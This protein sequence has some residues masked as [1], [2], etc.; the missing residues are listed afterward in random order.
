MTQIFSSSRGGGP[1]IFYD[2]AKAFSEMG[3]EVYIIC[4]VATDIIA[5]ENV[6]I[7]TVKP[8]LNI[9][10]ELPPSLIANLRYVINSLIVGERLVRRHKIQLIHTNSFTPVIAGSVLSKMKGIPM[11][12]SIYDVFA[13]TE[14]SN[15]SKWAHYNK[16]PQ[17][18]SL[19][20]RLYERISLRMP[21]DLIH[22]VSKTSK[23][24][25]S[26]YQHRR[27]IRVVYPAI[28]IGNYESVS[29][30]YDNF[31][32]FIGRLVFYKNVDVLIKAYVEVVKVMPMSKLVIVGEGPMKEEWHNLARTLGI[33]DNVLFAGHISH[34]SKMDLLGSCSALA[35]PSVFEG[36]GLVILESFAMKKPVLVADIH[37]FDELVE[38]EIDGFLIAH[39]DPHVWAM[40]IIRLLTNTKL[41][42]K[43]GENGAMK[44]I[45]K[46]G[47]EKYVASMESLYGE[48]VGIKS[49][50][51]EFD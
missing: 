46:F 38:H 50:N 13:D 39:D 14:R 51:E 48:V 43:M 4:N 15:W 11:I 3:H 16:V 40:A 25:I 36:F 9:T 29:I 24:D 6:K 8:S 17:Y 33:S 45:N 23:Q 22:S 37:P 44:Q 12:A 47:F 18:Y 32:L 7:F 42:R 1:L 10:Y 21:F 20:G 49:G 41:T 28:N 35:L 2:L 34:D 27:P 5:N 26:L 30:R 31:I 19:I